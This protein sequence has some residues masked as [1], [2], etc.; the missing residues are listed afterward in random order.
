MV[1]MSRPA[2]AALERLIEIARGDTAQSRRVANFL[3][4]WWNAKSCG[5]FD[6][7]DLQSVDAAIADDMVT[8]IQLIATRSESPCAYGYKTEFEKM[9]ADWRPHLAEPA[10]P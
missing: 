6:F 10:A 8:V 7:A 1:S 5:G 4:A 2:L 9:L 3:L